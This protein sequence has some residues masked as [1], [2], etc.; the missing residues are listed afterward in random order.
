MMS[1]AR[2]LKKQRERQSILN[3]LKLSSSQQIKKIPKQTEFLRESKDIV[4]T[5]SQGQPMGLKLE[6]PMK[7]QETIFGDLHPQIPEIANTRRKP[8]NI[9]EEASEPE[10]VKKRQSKKEKVKPAREKPIMEKNALEIEIAPPKP[11]QLHK[12]KL[13]QQEN[14]L[15]KFSMKRP[16]GNVVSI[17]Q[18]V[19]QPHFGFTPK[20]K[21]PPN[22]TGELSFKNQIPVGQVFFEKKSPNPTFSNLP[23]K[24]SVSTPSKNQKILHAMRQPIPEKNDR[25]NMPI[26][27]NQVS[28]N[29]SQKKEETEEEFDFEDFGF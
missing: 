4:R 27:T 16:H 18:K 15:G 23:Q 19:S 29:E 12:I 3:S 17:D 24:S 5:I 22:K 2:F 25:E 13:E 26:S 8:I 14:N 6:V 1:Q 11:K 7:T 28:E 21:T 10:K 20:P 9:E